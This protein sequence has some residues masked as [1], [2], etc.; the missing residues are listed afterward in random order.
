MRCS[1]ASRSSLDRSALEAET[2]LAEDQGERSPDLV[3]YLAAGN[4]G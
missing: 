4:A 1:A 2:G 3:G